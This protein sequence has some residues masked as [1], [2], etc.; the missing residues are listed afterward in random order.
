MKKSIRTLCACGLC[1]TLLGS[2][3]TGCSL[4]NNLPT[5]KR[6]NSVNQ[7]ELVTSIKSKYSGSQ[8]SNYN[9]P[10][11]NV[12]KNHIFTYDNVCE[13]FW[14]LEAYDCFSVYY[15]SNLSQAV[16]ISIDADYDTKTVTIK[17]NLTFSFEDEQGSTANDGTWGSRSKFW[18]VQK[19]D[20]KT[21]KMLD[22]PVVTV[23]TTKEEM[24]TPTVSQG[25]A[26]DGNYRLSWKE[27][28]GADYYEVYEYQPGMDAAFLEA[29]TEDTSCN[30]SQ[31]KTAIEYEQHF[32]ETYANTEID[33]SKRYTMNS[34]LDTESGYFVV[35]RK[36]DGT[37]SGMSN[38]CMVS[39]IANQIPR[40][41][42]DQF[43]TEYEGDSALCLPTYVDMEMLDGSIG[44]FL[45]QYADSKITLLT[46]DS[47]VV[48]C[49]IKNLPIEMKALTFSG[50]D[51]DAFREDAKKLKE[52]EEALSTK[53]VTTDVEIDIPYVPDTDSDLPDTSS[54]SVEDPE[55]PTAEDPITEEPT[56][57]E[58]TSEE[59]FTEE[60]PDSKQETLSLSTSIQD[61]VVAN[62]ALSEWL[63]INM[64]AH[65]EEISL[66][67][68]PESSDSE[69]LMDAFLEAYTQN[70]LIGIMSRLNYNY[71]KNCF[72][73]EYVLSEEETVQMQEASLNKAKEIAKEIIKDSMS[74]YEKEVAI[75]Q[76]LCENGSYNDKI[77]DYINSDGTI[78]SEATHE[79][80]NS[81]TPYGILVENLGVCESYSEAFLLLARE[82]RLNAVIETGTMDGV[83]HE[84][85]R[86]QLDGSWYTIDTTN[87]DSEYLPNI[88]FNL[89][90]DLAATRLMQ[91]NDGFIDEYTG[92]YTASG[93]DNE[94]YTK[95]NLFAE[96]S[97]TAANLL[98]ESISKNQ[99]ATIR[100]PAD[101]E[102]ASVTEIA[103]EAVN[104]A[105]LPSC[106]F[107][108]NCGVL[109]LV[110]Q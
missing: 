2:T 38:T 17:P 60:K 105:N 84:W 64:L 57:E 53:S 100:I 29:T 94:Y 31:F 87:N 18:L 104:K 33:T 7:T 25:I 62:S 1:I 44:Q 67:D 37:H 10:M 86:I 75:N 83:N 45:I 46:D 9:D 40:T 80:A 68:F 11:Y 102:E 89:P 92:N 78:D 107:Y 65:N 90:D 56:S 34:M 42:S 108:Y 76:Y 79:F 110:K 66:E 106:K 36:N 59:S 16:D 28:E 15:D 98:A 96:D 20:L 21:G 26:E 103:Q 4:K 3:L 77:M 13:D 6:K 85:N 91:D 52:R 5:S 12:E 82:A 50:M 49:K 27:V 55:A 61:T 14:N 97:S 41:D 101:T 88:Y 24:N 54:P 74:D 72:V 93:M 48:E 69:Y 51:W 30:F 22:K 43:Q 99:M 58:P 63:A 39:D 71:E 8:T 95:S 73:V 23:F 70:P 35:A 47:I 19:V 81:F 109:S 32:N